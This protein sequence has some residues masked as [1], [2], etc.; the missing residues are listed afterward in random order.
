MFFEGSE[1]KAEV[2]INSSNF[3]L[4]TD[5]NDTFWQKLVTCCNAK[6][7]S[8]ISND[9]CKAFLLS[10]SSLFV[11]SDRFLI[12]TCG[13]TT[14]VN[15]IEYFLKHIDNQH[16]VQ[17]IYQRKNEYFSHAQL[18]CFSDDTKLLS[19]LIDGKAYR[20]GEMDSH[21]NYIFHQNNTYQAALEDKTYEL[22][23]YQISDQASNLLTTQGLS[24]QRIRDFFHIDTLLPDFLI[25]DFVFEPYGYSLNAIKDD[26]YLTLHVTPQ[27]LSSYISFES[28]LNLIELAPQI[29]SIL[30]PASFDLLS[31]NELE[32]VEKVQT[33]ISTEYV[34]KALVKDTLSNGYFVCFANFIK[35]QINYTKPAQLA[36][37]GESHAL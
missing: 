12:L 35:P 25:D 34:S 9:K 21:H 4:L 19:Q 5:I 11:W 23:A 22:L 10:E 16:I 3:S 7:L 27:A 6:I 24:A 26:K 20:F 17:V 1:K 31:F 30:Q 28:N 18:S 13:I 15:S 2:I 14:L 33:A 32:F 29:L 8:T 37:T 36:L